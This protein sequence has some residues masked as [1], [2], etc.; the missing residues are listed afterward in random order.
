M[1]TT[2]K[3]IQTTLVHALETCSYI[4][5]EIAK[6]RSAKAAGA[7]TGTT[8]GAPDL[9]VSHPD[10]HEGQWL[11]I[12]LKTATG[13]LRPAQAALHARGRIIVCR[14]VAE[15]IEAVLDVDSIEGRSAWPH[16]A[17]LRRMKRDF[18]DMPGEPRYLPQP[19]DFYARAVDSMTA[20]DNE[21][22]AP[23]HPP[24]SVTHGGGK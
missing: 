14:S 15:G 9:L 4:V 18:M 17:K 21:A 24:S 3:S 19:G 10:W 11:G 7:W 2:E 22:P 16:A 8:P 23:V 1:K 6:G 5:L 13:R 12:E 20:E